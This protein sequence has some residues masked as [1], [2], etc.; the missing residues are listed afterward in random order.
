MKRRKINPQNGTVYRIY[1]QFDFLS[2]QILHWSDFGIL[3]FFMNA[4][5]VD[6]KNQED[7]KVLQKQLIILPSRHGWF[8]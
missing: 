2:L 8:I 7:I 6:D 3:E 5:K 4:P 1:I